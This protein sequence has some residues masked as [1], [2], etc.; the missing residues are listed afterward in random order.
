MGDNIAQ[1]EE[2]TVFISYSHADS[3]MVLPVAERLK[4][5]GVKVWLDKW[6]L[7]IGNKFVN[8]IEIALSNASAVVLFVSKKSIKSGWVK[9][10]YETAKIYSVQNGTKILPVV[11]DK[12]SLPPFLMGTQAAFLSNGFVS[13]C[14]DLVDAVAGDTALYDFERTLRSYQNTPFDMDQSKNGRRKNQAILIATTICKE[15]QRGVFLSMNAGATVGNYE[16]G[17][18]KWGW[19]TTRDFAQWM[20]LKY[21]VKVL[22]DAP[23]SKYSSKNSP[24]W[25]IDELYSHILSADREFGLTLSSSVDRY[26]AGDIGRLLEALTN[27]EFVL[28][29]LKSTDS[30]NEE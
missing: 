20:V 25:F 7:R 9:E 23:P 2:K 11:L 10:E 8:E 3:D 1:L 21:A 13:V 26:L 16:R 12:T 15:R 17:V 4:S 29:E 18:L 5:V 30:E 6:E 14:T 28:N 24:T 27:R 22:S 19:N